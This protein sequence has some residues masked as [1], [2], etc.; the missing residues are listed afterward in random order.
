MVHQSVSAEPMTSRQAR[1]MSK[2]RSLTGAA[3][4]EICDASGGRIGAVSWRA[5]VIAR[6]NKCGLVDRG[7]TGGASEAGGFFCRKAF[8]VVEATMAINSTCS[9]SQQHTQENSN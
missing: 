7:G 4:L 2:T 3:V 5:N 9:V 8:G 1:V 6:T